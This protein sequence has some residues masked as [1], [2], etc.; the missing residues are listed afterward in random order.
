MENLREYLSTNSSGNASMC[1]CSVVY[2]FSLFY[3]FYLSIFFFFGGGGGGMGGTTA[4]KNEMG[5][6]L[7]VC[8]REGE[9]S[10][11]K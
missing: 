2:S 6:C 8:H 1:M 9:F 10:L 3:L 7:S 4:S 5:P 11:V